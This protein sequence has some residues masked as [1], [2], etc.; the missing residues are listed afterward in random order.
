MQLMTRGKLAVR[1]VVL[2]S[3]TR[4]VAGEPLLCVK[5]RHAQLPPVP[6][7]NAEAPVQEAQWMYCL[8]GVWILFAADIALHLEDLHSSADTKDLLFVSVP[9]CLLSID[10]ARREVLS[11]EAGT[12]FCSPLRRLDKETV[13]AARQA[14]GQWRAVTPTLLAPHCAKYCIPSSLIGTTPTSREDKEY[15]L[16]LSIFSERVPAGLQC[17]NPSPF[18]QMSLLTA[19]WAVDPPVSPSSMKQ[20]QCCVNE[21]LAE[22][23]STMKQELASQRLLAEEVW[24]FHGTYSHNVDSILLNGLL[25]GGVDPGV[26]AVHGSSLGYG[27]YTCKLPTGCIIRNPAVL[28]LARALLVKTQ[29][30]LDARYHA[31]EENAQLLFRDSRLLLPIY[32]LHL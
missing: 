9:G 28:I 15:K 22:R 1:R 8:R 29:G 26:V 19:A 11:L 25:I 10:L 31:G 3:T 27:I 7:F 5:Q 24:V 18:P 14:A 4:V 23:F 13:A 21:Q 20:I 30:S 17:K 32:A 16:A 2:P 6:V 12:L